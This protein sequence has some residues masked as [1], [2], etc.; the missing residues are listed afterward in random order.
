MAWW[1]KIKPDSECL[2]A[3]DSN[4]VLEADKLFFTNKPS[5]YLT[6]LKSKNRTRIGTVRGQISQEGGL[7]KEYKALKIDRTNLLFDYPLQLPNNFTIILKCTVNTS[8]KFLSNNG[9]D[10]GPAYKVDPNSSIPEEGSWVLEGFRPDTTILGNQRFEQRYDL[11]TVILSGSIDSKNVYIETNYGKELIPANSESFRT[12]L[13]SQ[14]LSTVGAGVGEPSWSLHA[15]IIA[16]G[17]FSSIL[18]EEEIEDILLEVDKDFL[19]GYV[20]TGRNY[21]TPQDYLHQ[22]YFNIKDK[23]YLDLEQHKIPFLGG[24]SFKPDTLFTNLK[25]GDPEEVLPILGVSL[26]DKIS[27]LESL[28]VL[29]RNMF[30]IRDIVLKEE[31][32]IK[33]KLYLYEKN[34][35]SLIKVTVSDQEG[36]F[37]FNN[38]NPELEYIVRASDNSY[39]FKSILKDYNI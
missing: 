11:Q 23:N 37:Q 6:F 34:Q 5:R 36:V 27:S 31:Y 7:V 38:L 35:G 24:L 39:Q 20:N 26:S 18:T 10:F 25:R 12:F 1:S 13:V 9:S 21:K 4:S 8:S 17:V 33:T 19:I 29:Y 28:S 15:D 2:F 16:F 14:S 32:P 30:S 22:G 3:I